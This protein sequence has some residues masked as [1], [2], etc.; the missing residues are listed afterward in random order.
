[1]HP[2]V[3]FD[4]RGR[5]IVNFRHDFSLGPGH[6]Y[7]I[8]EG[9]RDE[10]ELATIRAHSFFGTN[11]GVEFTNINGSSESASRLPLPFCRN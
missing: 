3:L 2:A 7:R 6:K 9:D 11:M 8:Y 4:L 5:P 1:M 10:R